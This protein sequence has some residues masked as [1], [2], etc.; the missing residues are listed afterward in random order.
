[1]YDDGHTPELIEEY[2]DTE[3]AGL[4][5]LKGYNYTEIAQ[6]MGITPKKAK[7]YVQKY[8]ELI[9]FQATSDPDFLDRVEENTIL[10]LKQ[11]DELSKEAWETVKIS[12]DQGSLSSRINSLKLAGE[13]LSQ[14]GK[15]LQLM[16]G[17]V[18]SS[19][20]ARMARAESVNLILASIIKEI[21]STCDVCRP[22]A[23][24]RLQ[25]AFA[26]MGSV[27]DALEPE[28]I[29]AEVVEDEEL[30]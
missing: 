8:M 21:I 4:L 15:L 2:N 6:E 28:P 17:K 27:E 16:G 20:I 3:Q 26:A 12:T 18:D 24:R 1:M 23:H 30:P 9:R 25:E 5:K 7:A 29:Y 19:Y 10:F 14:K 22:E 13:F 11:F